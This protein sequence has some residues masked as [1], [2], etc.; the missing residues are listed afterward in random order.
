[1]NL[2]FEV[3][4]GGG[5]TLNLVLVDPIPRGL[6]PNPQL[7]TYVEAAASRRLGNGAVAIL[8]E[9]EALAEIENADAF[10]V[11][12][13]LAY[14]NG[15]LLKLSEACHTKHVPIG[16]WSTDDPYEFDLNYKNKHVFDWIWT[17]DKG[18]V[19]FYNSRSV[20]HL[21]LAAD[22]EAHGHQFC[23]ESDYLYDVSFIGIEFPLR[24]EIIVNLASTLRGLKTA[25]IGPHWAIPEPFV[26]KR[27]VTNVEAAL[28]SNRSRV[29]LC[30]GRGES[31]FFNSTGMV[32]STP[33][34]RLFEVGAASTVQVATWHQ[35]E[36]Q[37]YY[38]LDEEIIYAEGLDDMNEKVVAYVGDRDLRGKVAQ[39]AAK[40]TH[41]EHL[42]DHR[43]ARVI[44][45][46][47][48][49]QNR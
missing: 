5:W 26:Q 20:E 12:A 49:L 32:P 39:A 45:R 14:A 36:V 31:N 28:I 30:L 9:R 18:S 6:H 4:R 43:M 15:W 11:F 40:K 2:S 27:R 19:A 41:D 46:F 48:V 8:T 25:V 35:P 3:Q 17:T 10:L 34:P 42:Y 7:L 33:G 23:D 21:P 44:E 16:Y 29:V 24:R 1:V 22:W 37:E 47:E 13:T 38:L